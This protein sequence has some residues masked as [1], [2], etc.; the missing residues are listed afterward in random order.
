MGL[1][2]GDREKY[3]DERVRAKE[4][5][6]ASHS[7]VYSLIRIHPF[8]FYYYLRSL[9]VTARTPPQTHASASPAAPRAHLFAIT[10][11]LTGGEGGASE[12]GGAADGGYGGGRRDRSTGRLC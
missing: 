7:L 10:R 6:L 11:A 8:A 12:F 2:G 9:A 1:A 3:R 4:Q 5:H